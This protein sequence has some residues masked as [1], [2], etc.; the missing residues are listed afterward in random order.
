[1]P[2][3]PR[4]H[5]FIIYQDSYEWPVEFFCPSTV[6]PLIR[7]FAFCSLS[8]PWSTRVQKL[9]ILLSTGSKSVVAEGY[10]TMFMS[11]ASLPLTREAFYH[12]MSTQEEG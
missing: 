4:L 6:V 3:V 2:T 12:L 5:V 8:Y 7:G 10:I 9:V 1:M 11:F